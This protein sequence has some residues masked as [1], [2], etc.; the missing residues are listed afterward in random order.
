[1]TALHPHFG[2]VE[3]VRKLDDKLTLVILPN[4]TLAEVTSALLIPLK[5]KPNGKPA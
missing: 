1:M 4:K 5:E 3:I 2:E